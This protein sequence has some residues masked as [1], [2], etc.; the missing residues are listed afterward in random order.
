VTL[1]DDATTYVEKPVAVPPPVHVSQ[2][3]TTPPEEIEGEERLVAPPAPPPAPPRRGLH[4]AVLGVTVAAAILLVAMITFA[5]LQSTAGVSS[6]SAPPTTPSSPTTA[7]ALP[8][9]ARPTTP[10]PTPTEPTTTSAIPKEAFFG[11]W[12]QH[13]MSVTLAPDGSAHYAVWE[14]VANGTSWSATWS[15]IT[16]IKAMIVVSK[17]LESHGDSSGLDLDRYSG[18]A[19]TFTVRSDGYATITAPSGDPITLCPRSTSFRDTQGLCGA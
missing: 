2:W 3:G 5:I 19:F 1:T 14:G 9:V 16:S 17:Q 8:T 13:S 12:G 7:I 10:A 4:P 18:E 15:P 6:H 11:E